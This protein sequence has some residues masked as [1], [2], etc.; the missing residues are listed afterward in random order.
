MAEQ[1]LVVEDD[2]ALNDLLREELRE[3]GHAVT[4]VATA[5]GAAEE[6]TGN[7]PDLVVSDLR[8]PG[9][10]GM[11][12]L[13]QIREFPVPPAFLVITAFGSIPQAVEALKAGADDFLTKPL[14]LDHL[15]LSVE[16]ALETRRLRKEV[17]RYRELLGSETFHGI[18]GRSRVMRMLFEQVSQVARAAGSVLVVGESGTGKELVARAIHAESDRRTQPFL[19]INCAGI[20]DELM[21]SELFGHVAG[22]FTGATRARRGLLQE[23]DGGTILLDEIGEMPVAMQAKLLRVLQDGLVRPVGGNREEQVDVRIVAATNRDLEA[24]V[25]DGGFREDLYYRLE[26]FALE[27]PPLRERGEDVELLAARMVGEVAARLGRSV[28]GISADALAVLHRYEFPG[29]VRELQ[30]AMERAV[31]FCTGEEV[32]LEDLPGRIR[33]A[34]RAEQVSGEPGRAGPGLPAN[35]LGDDTLPTLGDVELRY[36]RYVLQ[37]TGGNKRRAAA[38]LGIG[39]RTLYRRLGDGADEAAE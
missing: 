8:L 1:I 31:T 34:S 25:R 21:E 11:T 17:R 38:L 22:A 13:N 27:I 28:H 32:Q 35:L 29:N 19:A 3:A 5:E 26:T 10:D 20:P 16:R 37:Q 24:A 33:K 30:N 6:L 39:R 7:L 36:I 23:A 2:A 14:D 9:A 15:V 18:L 4:S 12:L